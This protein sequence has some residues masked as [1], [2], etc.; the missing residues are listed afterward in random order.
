M[1]EIDSEKRLIGYVHALEAIDPSTDPDQPLAG[2]EEM[3]K[4]WSHLQEISLSED[5]Y[6]R[7]LAKQRH[8]T[9]CAADSAR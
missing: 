8:Q 3:Q 5:L 2:E 7:E 1:T 6:K 9:G 4:R